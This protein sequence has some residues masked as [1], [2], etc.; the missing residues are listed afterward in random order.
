MFIFTAGLWLFIIATVILLILVIATWK[1]RGTNTG[2]AFQLL[3]LSA[4]IWLV[5]FS[6]ETAANTLPLKIIFANLQ[7]IGIASIPGIWLYLTIS[8]QGKTRP[9]SFWL[10]LAVIPILSNLLIWTNPY[11]H[12]FRGTPTLDTSS[13]PFSILVND[14]Q[15]WFYSIHAPYGYLVI[16]AALHMLARGISAMQPIYRMQMYILVT[17]LVLPVLTDVLYV[18]GISPINY[19]NIT[20]AVF[21]VSAAILALGLFRYQFLNIR[22]MAHELIIQHLQDGVIVLDHR[23]RIVDFNPAARK[24]AELDEAMIGKTPAEL[25]SKVLQFI[26]H[27]VGT[28]QKLSEFQNPDEHKPY[29]DIQVTRIK[30][31]T[32][33]FVGHTVS[34]RD[35][36]ERVE[37]FQ[38]VQYNATIDDMTGALNRKQFYELCL[39]QV[40]QL[41]S[42]PNFDL[43]II[44]FDLD[45]FKRINDRYGHNVGDKALKLV[46]KKIRST[47]RP[48]DIFGRIGGDEF[49]VIFTGADSHNAMQTAERLRSGIEKLRLSDKKQ[50]VK[51]TSSFGLYTAS[52]QTGKLPG[53]EEIINLADQAMYKAKRS[54]GNQIVI[55]KQDRRR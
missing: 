38:K 54:G 6:F 52:N 31:P 49:A 4:I 53:L 51:L 42:L 24:L 2:K 32:G 9:L 45:G 10:M 22:P 18:F 47:L 28:E 8:F 7:F 11:H 48:T 43:T 27:A 39:Q 55:S 25:E 16:L 17:A 23:N 3:S 20:P 12:W 50:R 30:T 13:A 26:G 33:Q 19:Y 35:I 1:Y 36:T 46:A 21:S 29:L 34:L 37:L 5:G 41:R 15:F 44:L 40:Q 14:Y